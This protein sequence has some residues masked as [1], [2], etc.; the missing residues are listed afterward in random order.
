MKKFFSKILSFLGTLFTNLDEWIHEHVQPSIETVQRLKAIVDGTLGNVVVTLIPGDADDK[1]RD[2][3]SQNL[4]K[5]LYTLQVGASVVNAPNFETKVSMLVNILRATPVG[6]RGGVYLKIASAMAKA[7]GNDE[8]VKGHSVD[9]LTQM[10]YSKLIEGATAET[11]PV[12]KYSKPAK[13]VAAAPA[14]TV[15]LAAPKT[16]TPKAASTKKGK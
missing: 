16:A 5:A 3:V 8:T 1:F 7:S 4:T 2:W 13:V 6:L 15:V 11:L 10:Q 14:K 12:D 9:L